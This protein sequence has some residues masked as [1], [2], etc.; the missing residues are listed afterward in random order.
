MTMYLIGQPNDQEAPLDMIKI[1]N[2]MAVINNM[3][4]RLNAAAN[5]GWGKYPVIP[6][7]VPTPEERV[8]GSDDDRLFVV[9]WPVE[10]YSS[11]VT[12]WEYL[13]G[14]VL[15]RLGSSLAFPLGQGTYAATLY[16]MAQ[17]VGMSAQVALTSL[18]GYKTVDDGLDAAIQLSIELKR[19]IQP[20]TPKEKPSKSF[21]SAGVV[22]SLVVAAAAGVGIVYRLRT[23][24]EGA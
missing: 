21:W 16:E 20:E 11:W 3:I 15:Q 1:E 10:E 14:R 9:A 24:K 22:V 8:V 17:D 23:K 13:A 6:Q 18:R 5:G 2:A 4:K 19:K 7:T 12:A